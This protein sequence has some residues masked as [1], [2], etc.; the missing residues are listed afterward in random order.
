MYK[1]EKKSSGYLL[2]FGGFID[3]AEMQRWLDESKQVLTTAQAPYGVI[4]DMRT[5]KPLAPDVQTI[6]VTGQGLYKEKG[7]QRSAV[8]LNDAVTT[9]QFKRLAQQSGI[10]AFERY[11]D[12]S[13]TPEWA[14]VAVAWVRDAVDCDK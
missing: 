5:L 11:I 10:Y 8:V 9:I 3:A 6:M 4:V 2:T 12:A 13:A 7:M 14:K 1:I